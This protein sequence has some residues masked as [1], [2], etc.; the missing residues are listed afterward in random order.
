MDW[1]RITTRNPRRVFTSM[2]FCKFKSSNL[3]TRSRDFVP[4]SSSMAKRI[5]SLTNQLSLL[6][7][8]YGANAFEINDIQEHETGPRESGDYNVTIITLARIMD[9]F[10]TD[11]SELFARQGYSPSVKLPRVLGIEAVGVVQ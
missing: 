11:S 7:I 4:L 3:I 2:V 5:W 10:A 9:Q 8:S 6:K 1:L